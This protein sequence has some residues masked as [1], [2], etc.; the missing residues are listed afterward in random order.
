MKKRNPSLDTVTLS[1]NAK[2]AR[3]ISRGPIDAKDILTACLC[4]VF[5]SAI[6]GSTSITTSFP[7]AFNDAREI[8]DALAKAAAHLKGLKFSVNL[9]HDEIEIDWSRS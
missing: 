9:R 1:I 3:D 8:E 6:S 4:E 7:N 5:A 2:I